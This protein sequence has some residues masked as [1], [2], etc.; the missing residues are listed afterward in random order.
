MLFF[1]YSL[2][3]GKVECRVYSMRCAK[4]FL[5][6]FANDRRMNVCIQSGSH[7]KVTTGINLLQ[8]NEIPA[9]QI[10]PARN[11]AK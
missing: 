9:N 4:T 11:K 1:E 10:K 8:Y 7:F 5:L 6:F 2:L 3:F